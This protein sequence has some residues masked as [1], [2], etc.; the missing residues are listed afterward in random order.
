MTQYEHLIAFLG[1]TLGPCY[2][3]VL[4]DLTGETPAVAIIHNG[5]ISGRSTGAPMMSTEQRLIEDGAFRDKDHVANYRGFA[6]NGKTLRCSAFAVRNEAGEVVG[7]LSISFDDTKFLELSHTIFGI[8]HPDSYI[9]E[10][11]SIALTENVEE[12]NLTDSIADALD[13]AF[14][15]VL[16]KVNGVLTY[17]QKLEVVEILNRKNV[18]RI[19]G[20]IPV[21][22]KRIS[23]SQASVYRYLAEVRKNP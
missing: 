6:V 21:V 11:I 23:S 4:Y 15:Q 2:E 20:A 10:N 13:E 12:G 16:G 8:A 17:E 7:L 1:E 22:A 14:L 9:K 19:K 3:I 18:F 5:F